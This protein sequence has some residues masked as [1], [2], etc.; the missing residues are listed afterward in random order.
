[1]SEVAHT[2][3]EEAYVLRMVLQAPLFYCMV[4]GLSWLQDRKDLF[5]R[6]TA[7]RSFSER[8]FAQM[9]AD[10]VLK[11]LIAGAEITAKGLAGEIGKGAGRK[12]FEA[13]VKRLE[14]GFGI[15]SNDIPNGDGTVVLERGDLFS[16]LQKSGAIEDPEVLKLAE[17][18]SRELD[19]IKKSQP[20]YAVLDSDFEADADILARHVEGL[21]NVTMK[22]G[23]TIDI[24]GA[25]LPGK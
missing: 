19:E 16:K 8:G 6:D 10:L 1:M 24:S 21:R 9:I 4:R 23:R 25:R 11:A 18:L 2:I 22:S 5:P 12:T 3:R 15:S 7:G 17:A 14:E 20:T 13:L